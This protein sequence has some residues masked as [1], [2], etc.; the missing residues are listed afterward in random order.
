MSNVHRLKDS[1][2]IFFTTCNLSRGCREL[3][4]E[5]FAMILQVLDNLRRKLKFL[6]CG[7]VLMPDHWHALIFPPYPLTIS[8][9]MELVKSSSS[10]RLNRNRGTKGHNWEHQFWDRFI[11]DKQEFRERMEYMHFNPVRKNLVARPEEWRW[12]SY[13][14]FLLKAEAVAACPIRIDYVQLPENYHA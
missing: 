2:K 14:N 9:T 5:E 3:N 10:G 7:Y 6:L 8:K 12:S 1:D 11:R 4:D 13:N